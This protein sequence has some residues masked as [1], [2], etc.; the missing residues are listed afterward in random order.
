MS[1]I[2]SRNARYHKNGSWRHERENAFFA[3]TGFVVAAVT[4]SCGRQLSRLG[5]EDPHDPDDVLSADGALCQLFAAVD[6][7]C[8]VAAL[9]HDAI[10]CCVPANLAKILIRHRVFLWKIVQ[11]EE[12][13]QGTTSN[14]LGRGSEIQYAFGYRTGPVTE[15]S[16]HVQ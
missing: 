6:A 4:N 10:D 13:N 11:K 3:T 2:I 7:S 1:V 5:F 16:K 9:Q 14:R 8:H 15:W 12:V